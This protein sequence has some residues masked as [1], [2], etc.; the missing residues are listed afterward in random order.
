MNVDRI[1]FN[2]VLLLVI[3]ALFI[4]LERLKTVP[5]V[6]NPCIVYERPYRCG[7]ISVNQCMCDGSDK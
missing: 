3:R 1:D 6:G 7:L 4:T 5:Y 2:E